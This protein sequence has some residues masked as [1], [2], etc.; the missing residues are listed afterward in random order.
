MTDG[1]HSIG[2]PRTVRP[3]RPHPATRLLLLGVFAACLGT[4]AIDGFGLPDPE[5]RARYQHLLSEFRCPK[6]LNESLASSGA[7][8]AADLRRTVR[9]LM[10]E[11]ESDAAI[12]RHLQA[13]YG[14]FVLYDPP[15]RPATWLL[16]FSP[17]LLL[18]VAVLVL[19]RAARGRKATAPSDADRE[20]ARR[21]LEGK[22]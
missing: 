8:I 13:R 19:A 14:D 7:P 6:C 20:R 11:G 21:L 4:S 9:R 17:L 10:D 3:T 12:R 5:I 16:W 2:W 15:L 22:E 1:R 18:A